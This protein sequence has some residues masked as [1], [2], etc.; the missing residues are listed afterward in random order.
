LK[1]LV[2]TG[3]LV[4]LLY[5]MFGLAAGVFFFEKDFQMASEVQAQDEY[6]SVKFPI[7]TVPYSTSW[8]NTEDVGGLFKDQGKFYNI[9]RQKIENDT[10]YLTLKTNLSA[11]DRF[12]ELADQMT[13]ANQLD[14]KKPSPL[15][16]ALKSLLDLDK[17][18]WMSSTP[19]TSAGTVTSF[20]TSANYCHRNALVSTACLSLF[21][22][23][24][25]A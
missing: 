14:G 11:R 5:H 7:I 13:H 9:I 10:I 16:K 24:P 8:E 17:V 25:E 23:P 3:L 19:Y 12:L 2:P 1:A 4:L 21:G 18:Y 6:K 20:T 22:P 15:S